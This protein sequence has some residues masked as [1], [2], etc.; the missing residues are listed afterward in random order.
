MVETEGKPPQI[1]SERKLP[2][3]PT[4]GG[5]R[6]SWGDGFAQASA[7]EA[8]EVGQNGRATTAAI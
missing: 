1:S 2:S 8:T 7:A 6:G 5:D 4:G 3:I